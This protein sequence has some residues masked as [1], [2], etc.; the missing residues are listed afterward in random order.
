MLQ[1]VTA[2]LLED[3]VIGVQRGADG[4]AFIASGGL[5]V[6]ASKW[7]LIEDLAVPYAVERA[8]TRHGEIVRLAPADAVD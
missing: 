2:R 6:R 8:S 7:C 4:Q 1:F 5:N 3:G